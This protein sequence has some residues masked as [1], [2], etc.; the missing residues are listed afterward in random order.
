MSNDKQKTELADKEA[1][2]FASEAVMVTSEVYE[3]LKKIRPN[4]MAASGAL[5]KILLDMSIHI[6][7][8]NIEEAVELAT[9]Q[10]HTMARNTAPNTVH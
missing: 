6:T 5:T 10:I 3:V 8:G 7:D 2:Q 9:A 4:L 1:L